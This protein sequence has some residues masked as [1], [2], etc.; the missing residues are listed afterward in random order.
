MSDPMSFEKVSVEDAKKVLDGAPTAT[1]ALSKVVVADEQDWR[2]AR[3]F[4]PPTRL[5]EAAIAWLAELPADVRPSELP[6]AYPRIANRLSE[7]WPQSE[8]CDRYFDELTHDQ[9][10]T[11]MGFPAAVAQELAVMKKHYGGPVESQTQWD[12]QIYR[13]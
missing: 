12:N 1:E 6:R 5:N 2:W 8:E 11:R 13:R 4:S 10:G 3:A 7:L 9:R